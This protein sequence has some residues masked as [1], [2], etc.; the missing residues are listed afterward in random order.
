MKLT[1]RIIFRILIIMSITLTVWA[2]F[3]HNTII[4]VFNDEIDDSLEFMSEDLIYRTLNGEN[5]PSVDNGTNNTYFL[6][7]VT[8]EYANTHPNIQ[9]ANEIVYIAQ[10]EEE[11]PSRVL[12]TIFRDKNNIYYQL[13]VATPTVDTN[14]LKGTITHWVIILFIGLFLIIACV[15]FF[16]LEQN[17]K[18]LYKLLHLLDKNDIS[19]GVQPLDNPT[20]INEFKRLN[21]AALRSA[22]RN[23]QHYIQQKQFTGN[24]SHEMQ[25]PIAVCKSR[26]DFLM[27]TP[28]SEEQ[29][30]EII[31]TQNTLS[32]ISK[33][34]KDLLLLTKIDGGQFTEKSKVNISS[35]ISKYVEEYA[36]VYESHHIA[37]T[38]NIEND[39]ETYMNETLASILVT[40]L[41]KN[42]FTH[43]INNGIIHITTK[44]NT[45]TIANSSE[46]SPLNPTQ[47][48][49]C[50]YQ[51]HKKEGSTGLGL[52][53]VKEITNIYNFSIS[54][55]YENNLHIFSVN[56]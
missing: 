44:D 22:K 28:L 31:K 53:L 52:A 8:E 46:D 56:F 23:E 35:L 30:A 26:L 55:R 1:E 5:L 21:D 7:Q 16:V 12:R 36:M 45:F 6:E 48:F 13:T 3:F 2:L 33:L 49:E 37:L 32:Y 27:D 47:I 38:K 11:E 17:M 51:G 24:A 54:Y 14:D 40:N 9:Y 42:A 18:P 39:I 20:N 10:K 25:T 43:N 50:F 29:M 34:N 41:I 4:N 15:C 19:H